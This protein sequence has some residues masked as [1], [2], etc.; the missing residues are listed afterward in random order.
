METVTIAGNVIEYN[1][2]D[3]L[4]AKSEVYDVR[5]WSDVS[6][7]SDVRIAS[8]VR[9]ASD[10]SIFPGVRIASDVSIASG[11]RIESGVR[12]TVLKVTSLSLVYEYQ[13]DI[14]ETD[15]NV[16]VRMGCFTRTVVEWKA[17]FWNNEK[18]FPRGS[19]EGE[20]RLL[21]FNIAMDILGMARLEA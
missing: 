18:E 16:Y 7:G 8:G 13:T 14:I 19:E 12:G 21:A 15:E 20:R 3:E 9:I 4:V 1:G 17:D 10:V 11:V 6:I 2:N 5:I